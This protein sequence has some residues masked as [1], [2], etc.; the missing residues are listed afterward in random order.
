MDTVRHHGEKIS[1]E[2]RDA[3]TLRYKRITKAINSEF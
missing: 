3:I 1:K 2:L